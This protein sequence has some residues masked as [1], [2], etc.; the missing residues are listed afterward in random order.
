M[1]HSLFSDIQ[2]LVQQTFLPSFSEP[3]PG[4]QVGQE[5]AFL[6]GATGFIGGYL[7]VALLRSKR[8][9]RYLCL[10]RGDQSAGARERLWKSLEKKG[11]SKEE[12][13]QTDITIVCGD[14]LK[15]GFGL[16]AAD[17]LL[18][19]EQADHVFHFAATMNWVTPFNQNILEN[20]A[21][22]REIISICAAGRLKK[23]HYAS[24][25]GLWT[26]LQHDREI[27]L[28]EDTH[29]HGDQLAGGYFQ[30]KWV[31]EQMLQE[32]RSKGIPINI[33]RI[34]DVKGSARDGHGDASNFGNLVMHYFI[35]TGK[36]IEK[37]EPEF[38]FIPV[39][40]LAECI[41]TICLRATNQTFQF[42]NQELISF[43]DIGE[44]MKAS[45]FKTDFMPMDQWL[46]ALHQDKTLL[47]RTLN[48]IFRKFS[49]GGHWPATSFYQIG[50]EMFTKKHDT[51][52]T[53]AAIATS[54]I[55][56]PFMKSDGTLTKYLHHLS[57]IQP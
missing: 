51:R 50:V 53:T 19:K 18:V 22:L 31:A 48:A 57:T 34:G 29:P 10:V 35:Q 56:A 5:T 49:P 28:E 47:G 7:L 44:T 55:T 13:E 39:D 43:I 14:I 37:A 24:S 2:T 52:N 42:S 54:G 33:Y 30:S 23:L 17:T 12:F 46:D 4:N 9:E 6:T 21:A 1:R 25:M 11:L 15:S 38:N 27:I 3:L 40:Y 36:V 20:L 32:A 16:S 41:A 26:L 8:F 45:G